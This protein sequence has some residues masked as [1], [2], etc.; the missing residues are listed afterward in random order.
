MVLS[1][2]RTLESQLFNVTTAISKVTLW[3]TA[4]AI[5]FMD[6]PTDFKG[7]KGGGGPPDSKGSY[8]YSASITSDSSSPQGGC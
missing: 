1:P 5:S 8:A 3:I 4:I 2:E 7:K 6:T